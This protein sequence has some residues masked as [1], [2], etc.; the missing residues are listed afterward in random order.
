MLPHLTATSTRTSRQLL[1]I[2]LLIRDIEIIKH[3]KRTMRIARPEDVMLEVIAGIAELVLCM[4]TSWDRE[5]L[6]ELFEGVSHPTYQLDALRLCR[7]GLTFGLKKEE[8]DR[9]PDDR[10][11]AA[12]QPKA[13]CRSEVYSMNSDGGDQKDNGVKARYSEGKVRPTMNLK[14]HNVAVAKPIPS[15]HRYKGYTSAL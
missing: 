4:Y 10:Q 11:R 3:V 1:R 2:P 13:P 7:V 12:Y 6:I 5:D 14:P 9:N 8:E 15:S